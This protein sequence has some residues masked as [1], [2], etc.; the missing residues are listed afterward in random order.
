MARRR[1][2][3]TPRSRRFELPRISFAWLGRINWHVV[4]QTCKAMAWLITFGAIIA[5]WIIFVPKLQAFA[6]HHNSAATINLRFADQP[7]WVRGEL[8]QTLLRTAKMQL[9]SGGD[10][11]D[12]NELIA[13]RQALLT[14]GWFD[15]VDQVR[16]VREDVIEIQAHFVHP[17]ALIHDRDGHHLIDAAGKLLPRSYHDG[18]RLPTVTDQATGTTLPM[19]AINGTRFARP[20]RPGLMWEGADIVAALKVIG[21]IERQPWRSQITEIDVTGYTKDAPMKLRTDGSCMIVWGSPPGEER[22]LE[23]SALGKIDRLNFLFGRYRR[24]DGCHHGELDITDPQ[25]VATR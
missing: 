22:G 14:T 18:E 7:G 4:R 20:V 12:R 21:I 10:P 25:Y 16:R 1:K 19:L 2:T 9:D 15:S 6:S 13:V 11:F 8:A 3:S 17:Y 5:S 24:I 23:V